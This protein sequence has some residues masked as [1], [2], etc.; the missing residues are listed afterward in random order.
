[1][2]Q[3]ISMIAKSNP[4]NTVYAEEPLLSLFSA[5]DAIV[6]LSGVVLKLK[7]GIEST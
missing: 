1:M 3:N 2:T 4:P 6:D 5:F 7:R